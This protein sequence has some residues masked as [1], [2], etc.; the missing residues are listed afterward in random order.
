VENCPA[1]ILAGSPGNTFARKNVITVTPIM[2]GIVSI[3][4]RIMY[5]NK[6]LP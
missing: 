1:A 5:L 6:S 3:S 4:L 2:T